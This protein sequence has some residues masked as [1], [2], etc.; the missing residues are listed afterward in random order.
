MENNNDQ[1]VSP[2][3]E[4][5]V[6]KLNPGEEWQPDVARAFSRIQR[7]RAH[8]TARMWGMAAAAAVA[9]CAGVLAFPAPRV[10]A[11]RCVVACESLFMDKPAVS[12]DML[13]A[14]PAPDF[15][16]HDST[17]APVRLS[18]YRGKVVL[19]NFWATWCRP[20]NTEIPWFIEFEQAH[21]D[22]GFAVIGI[23]MDDDGWK[24]VKPY[25]AAQK[26]NYPIAVD[27]GIIAP[28]YGGVD[29]LPETV[30]IDREGRIVTRHVGLVT[31]E[32][33]ASEIAAL[34]KQ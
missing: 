29:S 17:G 22:Q 8:V 19:L 21:Q 15:V 5:R 3:V 1:N 2:W 13:N 20:C 4:E 12:F 24:S 16:V 34:L 27:D 25:L 23:S 28:K 18:D 26:I 9:V 33:Y 10:F 6:S 31:K 30:L 11:S 32:T 14:R 7:K